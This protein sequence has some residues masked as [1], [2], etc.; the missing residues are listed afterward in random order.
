MA[1][2]SKSASHLSDRSFFTERNINNPGKRRR[3]N[4]EIPEVTLS[5]PDRTDSERT[6]TE[7][8]LQQSSNQ[9]FFDER[10]AVNMDRLV[11]KKD[12]YES[13]IQFLTKCLTDK[14]VPLG[15]AIQVEPTIGNHDEEFLNKWY[16]KLNGFSFELMKDIVD[17]CKSTTTNLSTK[18][19][20]VDASIKSKLQPVKYKELSAALQKNQ[21]FR[22][23]NLQQRKVKKFNWL[24]YKS[25]QQQTPRVGRQ[26]EKL[27]PKNNNARSNY[28]ERS[29]SRSRTT[30]PS[31]AS[32]LKNK[33]NTEQ[34]KANNIHT[35]PTNPNRAEQIK[36][37]EE[38]I[39]ELRN[40]RNNDLQKPKNWR[41][42]PQG[43]ANN[44]HGSTAEISTKDV[45]S[46]IQ[47]TMQTLNAFAMRL[48][49]QSSLQTHQQM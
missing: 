49:N 46:L 13:H 21:E 33:S 38:Q 31:Y 18:I 7:N 29:R 36:K 23:R 35:T 43:G 24:K 30:K 34:R 27:E 28:N 42:A 41:S 22:K 48:D 12:R 4:G 17:F 3:E 32:V 20:E 11:D 47:S 19:K 15:L 2:R 6:I 45:M 14:V 10:E 44:N 37:L 16:E 40:Q 25:N 8:V 1:T 26:Q 5:P 39:Q 9:G